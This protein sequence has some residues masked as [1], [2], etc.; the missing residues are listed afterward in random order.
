[1]RTAAL[2]ACFPPYG[3]AAATLPRSI[4]AYSSSARL[5]CCRIFRLLLVSLLRSS[6]FKQFSVLH[7]LLT[8]LQRSYT[9]PDLTLTSPVGNMQHG[10][11]IFKRA[12]EEV[13]GGGASRNSQVGHS[14]TG[15]VTFAAVGRV[16]KPCYHAPR[17]FSAK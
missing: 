8:L 15:S 5:P 17:S 14:A 13:G 4:S 11:A 6:K 2:H 9:A 16:E 12:E 10:C 1:M 7:D 3:L